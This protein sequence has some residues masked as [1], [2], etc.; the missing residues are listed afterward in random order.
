VRRLE[1]SSAAAL[2]FGAVLMALWD[3]RWLLKAC[4]GSPGLLDDYRS[5]RVLGLSVLGDLNTAFLVAAIAVLWELAIVASWRHWRRAHALLCAAATLAGAL[6][7]AEAA[8]WRQFLTRER[9]ASTI[10]ERDT[11]GNLG[12]AWAGRYAGYYLSQSGRFFHVRGNCRGTWESWGRVTQQG[13]WLRLT[14]DEGGFAALPDNEEWVAPLTMRD[15]IRTLQSASNLQHLLPP[16]GGPSDEALSPDSPEAIGASLAK[17]MFASFVAHRPFKAK[18]MRASLVRPR[19]PL[20]HYLVG[21]SQMEGLLDAGAAQGLVGGMELCV[22]S[23][24]IRLVGVKA[25]ESVFRSGGAEPVPGGAIVTEC[26]WA[27]S[28]GS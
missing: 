22:G 7:V 6:A 18:V 16:P 2:A 9:E 28:R 20:L 5:S 21:G 25:Q 10:E 26:A 24:P 11:P 3:G 12:P 4:G 19:W 8:K 15:G 17:E 27:R 23:R 1:R 13:P 14:T